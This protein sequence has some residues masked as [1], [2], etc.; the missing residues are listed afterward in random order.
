MNILITKMM[1]ARFTT[2]TDRE[3]LCG[4]FDAILNHKKYK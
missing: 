3:R 1:T 2:N 4:G